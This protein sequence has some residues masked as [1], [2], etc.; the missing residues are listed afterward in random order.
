MADG[1]NARS[2]IGP[3]SSSEALQFLSR[4]VDDRKLSYLL[5]VVGDPL[6]LPL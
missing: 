4:Q 2:Y 6:F 5:L 1:E 3:E